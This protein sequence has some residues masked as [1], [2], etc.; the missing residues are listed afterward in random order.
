[1]LSAVCVF[2][3]WPGAFA[4]TPD[5]Q[6]TTSSCNPWIIQALPSEISFRQRICLGIAQMAS[7]GLALGS[8]ALAGLSQWRNSPKITPRDGDDYAVRFE[9]IYERQMARVTA[10]VLVA[11]IHHED[12]RYHRSHEKVAWRRIGAAFLSVVDSPG[13]DGSFRPALAPLAGS[14]GSGLTSMALYQRQNDL[15]AGLRRSGLAYS[16]YFVRA[17]FHEFSPEL[18]SLTPGF[19]RKRHEAISK[20]LTY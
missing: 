16:A 5:P 17:L 4:Q 20:A 8:G 19:V 7:P 10:D 18:W 13:E 3:A 2:T 9:H 6:L 14:L 15:S 1:M 12:P 11:A